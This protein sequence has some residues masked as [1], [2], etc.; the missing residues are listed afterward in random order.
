MQPDW[1]MTML[2]LQTENS[3]LIKNNQLTIT[4]KPEF[5]GI[6]PNIISHWKVDWNT[7]SSPNMILLEAK[8]NCA[9][10][11]K[12]KFWYMYIDMTQLYAAHFFSIHSYKDER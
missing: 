6:I 8:L 2:K 3:A 5:I 7:H 10:S 12:I 1:L 11:T 9:R 4:F